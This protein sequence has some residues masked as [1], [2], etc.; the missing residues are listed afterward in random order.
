VLGLMRS[1]KARK[2]SALPFGL[3]EQESFSRFTPCMA[4]TIR[5]GG[6]MVRPG[7]LL[8]AC[9]PLHVRWFHVELYLRDPT[10]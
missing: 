8:L 10:G 4:A 1:Y 2:G 6:F 5:A 9:C 7:A 3:I